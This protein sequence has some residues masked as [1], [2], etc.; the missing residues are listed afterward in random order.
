MLDKRQF[1]IGTEQINGWK[2]L[3]CLNGRYLS[4][5]EDLNVTTNHDGVFIIGDAWQADPAQCSPYEIIR[6][7]SGSTDDQTIFQAEESWCGKYVLI[8]GTRVFQDCSSLFPTFYDDR[9]NLSSS[10]RILAEKNGEKIRYPKAKHGV[11]STFIPG[12]CTMYPNIRKIM[13]SQVYDF[14]PGGGRAGLYERPLLPNGIREKDAETLERFSNCFIHSI[15]EMRKAISGDFKV[16]LTG[17]V[18][19]RTLLS[20]IEKS[21]VDYSC[22]TFENEFMHSGGDVEIPPVLCE[23]VGRP[24]SYFSL[25]KGSYSRKK[26]NEYLHHSAGT[27][28]DGDLYEYSHGVWDRVVGGKETVVLYSGI[29]ETAVEY[30]KGLQKNPTDLQEVLRVF[31]DMKYDP[32]RLASLH[33]WFTLLENSP[34]R[35]LITDS[36]RF[37][38]EQRGGAWMS[39][40]SQAFDVVDHGRMIQPCNCRL[41]LSYLFGWPEEER[42]AKAHQKEIIGYN[43]PEL[44][45]VPFADDYPR[46]KIPL[47]QKIKNRTKKYYYLTRWYGLNWLR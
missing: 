3:P 42:K 38:W 13:A 9:G 1:F 21:G 7:W 32:V 25:E 18:D 43:M 5:Q 33:E 4:W 28:R 24:Y 14:S 44:L 35:L 23:T 47:Y 20:L 36:D 30:F 16:A 45:R 34:W 2:S 17:G 40:I 41:F 26:E 19:S 39:Y 46:P 27:A 11:G 15:R 22:F 10:L 8:V 12:P 31:P 37:Y 29:W 6:G